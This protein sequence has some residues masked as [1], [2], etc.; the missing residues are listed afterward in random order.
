MGVKPSTS[1]SELNAHSFEMSKT[2]ELFILGATAAGC[3][4]GYA[5]YK[6]NENNQDQQK[7]K[8][9]HGLIESTSSAI[10]MREPGSDASGKRRGQDFKMIPGHDSVDIE[11]GNDSS[12]KRR[13][14]DFKMISGHDSEYI[15][16]GKDSSG[17]RRG[18]DFKM[19]PGH[20]SGTV[21]EHG[22]DSSGTV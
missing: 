16:R 5:F 22:I 1:N 4:M 7:E 8:M 3:A 9:K 6:N 21:K 19:I 13:G 10:D 15:E 14:Q 17:K 12:G 2:K 18:Q 20:D 11:P